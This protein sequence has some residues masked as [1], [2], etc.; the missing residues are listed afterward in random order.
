MSP[1][2][3]QTRL[4]VVLLLMGSSNS[5]AQSTGDGEEK[6]PPGRRFY[7]GRQIA[8]T[9]GYRG[10]A[11]LI[12]DDREQEERCSLMLANLGVTP[13]MTVCDMGCGNGFYALQLA[14]M[15]GPEGRVLGVDIQPQM[16]TYLKRRA[17]KQ[18][19]ENV[20]PIL[21][22]LI[23]P[24]LPD[25]EVDLILMVDVYHEFSHPEYMLKA[26]RKSLSPN[27]VIALLEYRAEDPNVPIKRLHKMSRAQIMKEFPGNGFKL[28]KEFEGLP[29][30][31]MMFFARDDAP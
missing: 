19:I 16:L 20:E 3:W 31:H 30:Q 13:G 27:G 10:A 12:R 23:D 28:V 14:K 11:W 21:G 2:H 25:G 29:W 7:M 22:T 24:K 26:M 5:L 17:A 18:K 4:V 1:S 8:Q 6:I 15:V 9:M